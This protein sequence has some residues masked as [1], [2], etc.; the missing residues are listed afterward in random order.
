M[1]APSCAKT[2]H[3]MVEAA[4]G[5]DDTGVPVVWLLCD[6]CGHLDRRQPPA[7]D[8]GQLDLFTDSEPAAGER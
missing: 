8:D 2:G 7:V 6:R 5:V 4:S 3:Q 1:T